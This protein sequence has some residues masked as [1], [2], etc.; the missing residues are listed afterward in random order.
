MN[1]DELLAWAKSSKPVV[2]VVFTDIVGSTLLAKENN[3]DEDEMAIVRQA[4]FAQADRLLA[5]YV[6]LKIKTNGDEHIAI[7]HEASASLRFAVSFHG[8]TGDHRV[9]IRAGIHFG[10][11]RIENGDI[12]GPTVDLSSRI[13]HLAK[14]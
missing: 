6:G 5:L 13:E 11:V 4:H 7:F 1:P 3:L 14:T 9:K 12:A 8:D 2:S 10:T